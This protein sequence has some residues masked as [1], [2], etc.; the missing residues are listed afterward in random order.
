[1]DSKGLGQTDDFVWGHSWGSYLGPELARRHR[2]WFHAY[3]ATGRIINFPESERRSFAYSL[4]AAKKA[5]NANA[6]A[7]LNSIAP[8]AAPGKRIDLKDGGIAHKWSDHFGGLMA[9]RTSQER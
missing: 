8:Y 4:A 6:L 9:Y 7:Q 1:M 5:N 2:E 3:I